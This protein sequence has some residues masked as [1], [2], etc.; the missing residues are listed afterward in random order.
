MAKRRMFTKEITESDAFMDLPLSS[1]ALYFHICMNS[2]D[3]GF[4]N[5]PN[6]VQRMIGASADDLKLLIAKR[7]LLVFDSGVVVVKHWKMHNYIRCDRYTPTV[8]QEEKRLLL[9][10]ENNSYTDNLLL[11]TDGMT[12]GIPNGY[13]MDTDGMTS[14]IHS[15]GQSSL[16]KV[17]KDKNSI[18][19]FKSI[20]DGLTDEQIETL[21][22]EIPYYDLLIL[23]I[24]KR[25]KEMPK[26]PYNYILA[27]A[28]N[29]EWQRNKNESN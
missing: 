21:V 29:E 27:C 11:D 5:Q 9:I 23:Y 10:K 6:K 12:S 26:N 4:C 14:G 16:G 22:A 25:L 18:V 28:R 8:Y 2:D 19:E 24:D 13:Q 15:L 20:E 1:Q 3:D 7:F 17:S